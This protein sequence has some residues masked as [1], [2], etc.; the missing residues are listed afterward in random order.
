MKK[1]CEK[2]VDEFKSELGRDLC[3]KEKDF[4]CWLYRE[5]KKEASQQIK[6]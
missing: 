3:S 5:H 1:T 4:I 2:L 6:L